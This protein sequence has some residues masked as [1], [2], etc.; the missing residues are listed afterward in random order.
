[1]TDISPHTIGTA[2]DVRLGA[3]LFDERIPGTRRVGVFVFVLILVAVFVLGSGDPI[4][5]GVVVLV[6]GWMLVHDVFSVFG[7]EHV[8]LTD[9]TLR[10]ERRLFG[11]VL[12]HVEIERVRILSVDVMPSPSGLD[13]FDEAEDRDQDVWGFDSG[14]IVVET[15]ADIYR[16]GQG[17]LKDREAA[18]ALV[19]RLKMMLALV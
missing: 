10:L 13:R 3:V 1:M 7:W 12:K 14:P 2:E 16:F 17:W 6:G 11:R 19:D 5:S 4:V 8:V 15:G 18:R 9:S